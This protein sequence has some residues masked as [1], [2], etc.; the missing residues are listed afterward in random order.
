MTALEGS[1]LAVCL[2]CLFRIVRPLKV[3]S[4]LKVTIFLIGTRVE[5]ERWYCFLEV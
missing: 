1:L 2:C 3:F 5:M 4:A